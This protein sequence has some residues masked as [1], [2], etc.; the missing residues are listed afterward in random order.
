MLFD[1]LVGF[2]D[3]IDS[4]FYIHVLGILNFVALV[5]QECTFVA[6][7]FIVLNAEEFSR[8][9]G[10]GEAHYKKRLD[11][12]FLQSSHDGLQVYHLCKRRKLLS[13][14]G[15]LQHA[16][17]LWLSQ[18]IVALLAYYVTTGDG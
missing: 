14:N 3:C 10:M 15:A 16:F 6:H 12:L 18:T 5:T 7:K 11:C 2:N 1:N 17:L 8:Q 9:L 4:G 13:I